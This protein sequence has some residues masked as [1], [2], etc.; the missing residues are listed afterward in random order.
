MHLNLLFQIQPSNPLNGMKVF[1]RCKKV[2]R[3]ASSVTN[4]LSIR[5]IRRTTLAFE[6]SRRVIALAQSTN[7]HVAAIN[8]T[9]SK[10]SVLL[11]IPDIL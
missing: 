1:D 8:H 11:A 9:L 6:E 5:S 3:I 4:R 10:L 2:L 7:I